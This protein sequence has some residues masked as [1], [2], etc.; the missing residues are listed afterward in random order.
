MVPS[1]G[2]SNE[3]RTAKRNSPGGWLVNVA[4]DVVLPMTTLEVI[5]GLRKGS[6]SEQSLVWR[7]GMHDWTAVLDVPQLRLAAGF[8][9]SPSASGC[10]ALDAASVRRAAGR[11]RLAS[12]HACALG[13]GTT[14]ANA[15]AVAAQFA[16]ADY[17]RSRCW[18]ASACA[19]TMG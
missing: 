10:R 5:D 15:D 11:S 17:G 6:L 18:R 9:S 7:I 13:R 12:A 3:K 2:S 19:R 16:R 14:R 8:V 1:V 4:D